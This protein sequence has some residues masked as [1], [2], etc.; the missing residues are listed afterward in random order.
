M[1]FNTYINIY[2]KKM[3]IVGVETYNDE[4]NFIFEER[5]NSTNILYINE[6]VEL[7]RKNGIQD[8][9][10]TYRYDRITNRIEGEWS[11]SQLKTKYIGLLLMKIDNYLKSV[12]D[13]IAA[14]TYA[15]K[16]IKNNKHCTYITSVNINNNGLKGQQ[17]E[18][19]I[20]IN[21]ILLE[22]KY[23]RTE[24]DKT[25]VNFSDNELKYFHFYNDEYIPN[26]LYRI[27]VELIRNIH[28]I[29]LKV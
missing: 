1:Y 9:F 22:L 15:E 27:C 10:F 6:F 17:T 25:P 2:I 7:F 8:I 13:E 3:N 18:T 24:L 21:D 28:L 19:N 26:M 4:W 23:W 20:Y 16:L 11:P 5:N 12:L 14:I 29:F